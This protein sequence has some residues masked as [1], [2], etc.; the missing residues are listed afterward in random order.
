M[1]FISTGKGNVRDCL[2]F[3]IEAGQKRRLGVR[4]ESKS[5]QIRCLEG[6]SLSVLQMFG[7]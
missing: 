6:H 4:E 5:T 1:K 2:E 7:N 3:R